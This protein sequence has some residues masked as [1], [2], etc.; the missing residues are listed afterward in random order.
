MSVADQHPAESRIPPETR[1]LVRLT[2]E[3]ANSL[4][5]ALQ[6]PP[7]GAGLL[8]GTIRENFVTI[9]AFRSFAF[10]DARQ[11]DSPGHSQVGKP[12]AEISG[13]LA[14]DP[15]L[16]GLELLGW[17]YTRHGSMGLLQR[18]VQFHNRHFPRATDL[19]LVL[20]AEGKQ[21][22]LL[23][24]FAR[25][26][27]APLSTQ[28]FLWGS[29]YLCDETPVTRPIDV[30]LEEK[31]KA[32]DVDASQPAVPATSEPPANIVAFLPA[33]PSPRA[34]ELLWVVS[35]ALF[36][37]ATGMT[38]LWAHARGQY[39]ALARDSQSV[40]TRIAPTSGLRI[41]AE[42]T[43]EGALLSWNHNA[44]IVRSAQQGILHIHDGSEQHT[45]Y[46]D[47]NDLANGS[48]VYRPQST[49][50]KV[51]LELLDNHGL[52]LS[53]DM[54]TFE[55]LKSAVRTDG[56]KT[57]VDAAAG[58]LTI[59]KRT[60][61]ETH[62]SAPAPIPALPAAPEAAPNYVAAR[63]LKQV[64]P[65]TKLFA[66][67]DIRE[68]AEVFVQVRIDERGGVIEAHVKNGT[69]DNGLLRSAALEAAKQWT[70]EPAKIDGKNIPSDH[71]IAFQF[72]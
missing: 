48:I 40:L 26:S 1:V 11:N 55:G 39:F 67:S 7:Q 24:L 66:V 63:A 35:A 16:T 60:N 29:S 42:S 36:V 23:Q 33:V 30:Y 4:S 72:H 37:L 64:M 58:A 3:F 47:P 20:N 12:A 46:L 13:A 44:S 52:P 59:P 51:R 56:P 57:A 5:I 25:T 69:N 31:N 68:G 17:S 61:R 41:Q 71:T 19:M 28:D 45:I 27:A 50:A 49:D 65:D 22:P 62:Q 2:P 53:N 21:E 10:W 14:G 18:D 6:T 15:E 54:R 34:N 9:R 32:D 8:F 70:F 43:G 38:F